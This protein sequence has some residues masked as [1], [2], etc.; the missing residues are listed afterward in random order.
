MPKNTIFIQTIFANHLLK[1]SLNTYFIVAITEV[2][3]G[4]DIFYHS[5]QKLLSFGL[6]RLITDSI[7][8]IAEVHHYF[9]QILIGREYSQQFTMPR[10]DVLLFH[11]N[12]ELLYVTRNINYL[13]IVLDIQNEG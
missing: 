6:R 2:V 5:R 12:P 13:G 10:H 11:V 4:V 1:I 9:P 3:C 7:Y 8:S